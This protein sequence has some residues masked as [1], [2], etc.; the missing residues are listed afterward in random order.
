MRVEFSN[1]VGIQALRVQGLKGRFALVDQL[2][3]QVHPIDELCYGV[4]HRR[5]QVQL[6]ARVEHWKRVVVQVSQNKAQFVLQRRG[7]DGPQ[8]RQLAAA[9]HPDDQAMPELRPRD[10][11]LLKGIVAPQSYTVGQVFR[12][13]SRAGKASHTS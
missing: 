12:R 13:V 6:S 9:R 4:C 2:A 1:I 8:R 11:D 7:S 3:D 10:R 5:E